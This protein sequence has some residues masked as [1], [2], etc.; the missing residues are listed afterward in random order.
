MKNLR[1]ARAEN[2]ILVAEDGGRYIDLFAGH[3]TVWLGH[4]NK[5]IAT[6]IIEQLERV[7]IT[8][9]LETAV[10]VEAQAMLE[11]FFPPSHGVMC[12]YSTGMEAA[13]FALRVARVAT[14]KVGAIGFEKSMHGKSLATAYLGW[15]N[16]DHVELRGFFRLPFVQSCGEDEILC[17]LGEVLTR[18][19]ISAVFIEPLQGIGG[20]YMASDRF[21]LEVFRLCREHGAL[22]VFDE[23]L[24]GFYKTGTAFFFS[25]LGFVPDIVLVGKA[26]GNG[27]PVS[28]VVV[29]KR[30]PIQRAMFPGSTYSGNPLA[31]AAV[32]ATLRQMRSMDLPRLVSRIEKT[33]VGS[34]GPLQEIGVALRGKGAMWLIELPPRFNTDAIVAR[35]SEGGVLVSH[36]G[37]QIRILPAATIEM[38]NLERACSIIREEVVRAHRDQPEGR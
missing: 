22:L 1:I 21:Y 36:A 4:T 10:A 29:S 28:G 26:M 12:V 6:G 14:G 20:G 8:G 35:I 33:I 15:D 25:D 18:H 5:Q 23:I 2:D 37:S 38:S 30:Y 9:G 17:R 16:K 7:W 3:G 11:T 34:L 27:F 13:E 31:A 19:P 32:V 24:T